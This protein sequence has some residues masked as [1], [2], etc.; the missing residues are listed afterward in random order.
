MAPSTPRQTG[1]C[2]VIFMIST[3][4]KPR[5]VPL[6]FRGIPRRVRHS[7]TRLPTTDSTGTFLPELSVF[8]RIRGLNFL[9]RFCPSSYPTRPTLYMLFAL[10]SVPSATPHSFTVKATLTSTTSIT[11]SSDSPEFPAVKSISSHTIRTTTLSMIA[12]G[13]TNDSASRPSPAAWPFVPQPKTSTSGLT[14]L[15]HGA[16]ASSSEGGGTRGSSPPTLCNRALDATSHG[17]SALPSSLLCGYLLRMASEILMSGSGVTTRVSWAASRKDGRG[18]ASSTTHCAA[19][20][21]FSFRT[22]FL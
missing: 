16:S 4:P 8:P 14:L 7:A 15:R 18:T 10:L 2:F 20:F 22:M 11:S 17:S 19:R 9:T 6:V 5:P 21:Q 13:G 3:F 1:A 12:N